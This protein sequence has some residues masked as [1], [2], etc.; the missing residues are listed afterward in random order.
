MNKE[1]IA[2]ELV[3]YECSTTQNDPLG[4]HK[5]DLSKLEV[6]E[7][8]DSNDFENFVNELIKIGGLSG[9]HKQ[10]LNSPCGIGIR[11]VYDD[12]SFTLITIT[13]ISSNEC[14]FLGEYNA[15]NEIGWTFGIAWQ[16]MIDDFK[17][18][19][20]KHFTTQI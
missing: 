9:K 17:A 15:G 16:Q 2:V 12:N 6:L 18:L 3:R 7:T 4:K 19:V 10:F 11:I 20:N 13:T 8:L 14:I 5:F 1:V